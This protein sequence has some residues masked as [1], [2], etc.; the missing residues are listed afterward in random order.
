MRTVNKNTP[1]ACIKKANDSQ[2]ELVEKLTYSMEGA[3]TRRESNHQGVS[4][5][6]QNTQNTTW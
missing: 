5:S 6:C 3:V 2:Y 4:S 1:K